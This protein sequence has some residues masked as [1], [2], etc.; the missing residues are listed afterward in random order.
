M[1]SRKNVALEVKVEKND[2]WLKPVYKN[3]TSDGKRQLKEAFIV[4]SDEI[5]R[6]TILRLRKNTGLN[7]SIAPQNKD[8]EKSETKTKI[9]EFAKENTL[10]VPDKKK[11]KK[12]TRYRT[13]SKLTLFECFDSQYPN[14]CTYDT[15]CK[16]WPKNYTK[17]KASDLGTCMCIT[18]Q[19]AELKMESLKN[20]IGAE[21][22]L[23]TVIENARQENFEAEN[24]FK[25]ALESLIEE[26]NKTVVGY[27]RWEKVKQ[28]EIN[29]NTGRAKSDK[30][31]R[32]SK[33]ESAEQLA[34]SML[35]EYENY[36][37]HLERDY[38]MKREIKAMKIEAEENEDIAVIHMDWVEQHKLSE[39][40]EVQS[41]YFA[42]RVC[43][44]IHTAYI[45]TKEDSHGAASI[46]DCPDHKAEAVHAAIKDNIIKLKENGKT[47][48]IIVSDGPTSQ[49]RNSKNV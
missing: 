41:A 4:A 13:S 1:M 44:D 5:E 3:L 10:E 15:F 11:V 48:V 19:N 7:F 34:E 38:T 32:K 24:N 20:H 8:Q 30:M 36:K 14:L 22:S 46:S 29:K 42:G 18:C 6:G 35:E 33:T 12:E 16:Y 26:E 31:M 17:P 49:Y 25:A 40:K 9:E 2:E 27:L 23:E 45:Y 28:T 43:Y 47:T 39:V 37:L 21:H